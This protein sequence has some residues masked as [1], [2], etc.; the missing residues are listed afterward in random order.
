MKE[1]LFVCTNICTFLIS[2]EVATYLGEYKKFNKGVCP[3]CGKPLE[4]RR[5]DGGFHV[6]WCSNYDCIH[7]TTV[8]NLYLK[9]RY[10]RKLNRRMAVVD[11][12]KATYKPVK[13]YE[14]L[15]EPRP[16]IECK[17][18]YTFSI[19]AGITYYCVPKKNLKDGN[20]MAVELGFPSEPDI[21]INH[22][23]D[24]KRNYKDTIYPNVPV[25]VVERLIEKHG[26]IKRY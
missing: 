5:N 24:D 22:F 21:L 12:L 13:G 16:R 7:A 20:Y 1:L 23:A 3:K 8:S 2:L 19:Q 11:F 9:W 25:F 15:L 6:Y 17:D 10:G 4:L 26:G 14:K 18:G